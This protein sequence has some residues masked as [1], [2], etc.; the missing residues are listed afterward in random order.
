VTPYYTDHS[1]TIYHGDCR[2]VVPGLPMKPSLVITD[3]PYALGSTRHEW[4]ATAAVGIGLYE[5][6]KR[7][8]KDG[9]MLVFSTSS[10]RGMEYTLGAIGK[11]LAF[12]RLLV[13]RKASSSKAAGPWQWDLVTIMAFGRATFGLATQSALI[14]SVEPRGKREHVSQVPSD[15]AEWLY[16]PFE[17]EGRLLLDPFMGSGRLLEP[18]VMA[19]HRVV[20]VE[21]EERYCELAVKRLCAVRGGLENAS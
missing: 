13:W 15:V 1:I 21:I 10:G 6:A 17:Q 20:G 2:E 5:T 9:A 11:T 12:N 3:P 7:L 18:A 19:R 8:S 4:N 16:R 14:E